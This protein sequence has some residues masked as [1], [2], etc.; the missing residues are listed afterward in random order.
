MSAIAGFLV[1]SLLEVA[2]SLKI[3]DFDKGKTCNKRTVHYNIRIVCLAY[4][5]SVARLLN[6]SETRSCY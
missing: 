5:D 3:K 1:F 4:F 2:S 6:Y